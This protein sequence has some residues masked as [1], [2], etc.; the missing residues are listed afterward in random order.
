[1]FLNKLSV[2]SARLVKLSF[3]NRMDHFVNQKTKL[4]YRNKRF[5]S[6]I[7]ANVIIK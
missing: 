5:F 6:K 7:L 1:M 3:D 2:S 4:H